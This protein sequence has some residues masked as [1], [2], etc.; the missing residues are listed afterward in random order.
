M[1]GTRIAIGVV[2]AAA[3]L[4]SVTVAGGASARG[5]QRISSCRP[6]TISRGHDDYLGAYKLRASGVRRSSHVRCGVARKLL[7]AAY[8]TGPLRVVRTVFYPP[9]GRPTYV[10]RGG[11]RC[12]NGAGGAVCWNVQRRVNA[13]PIEGLS[14]GMAVMANTRIVRG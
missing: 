4:A 13:I 3:L 8:G 1:R 14:H 9:S 10:L 7:K 11:W 5:S 2:L 6:F 12:G